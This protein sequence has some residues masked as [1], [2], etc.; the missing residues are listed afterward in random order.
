MTSV[1]KIVWFIS[2]CALSALLFPLH[3]QAGNEGPPELRVRRFANADG[4]YLRGAFS[5]LQDKRGF[6]LLGTERGLYRYDGYRCKAMFNDHRAEFN[7]EGD[8]I[9]ILALETEPAPGGSTR[10]WLGTKHHG[11]LRYDPLR[12]TLTH[13]PFGN[14]LTGK[15]GYPRITGIRFGGAGVV[16]VGTEGMGL[17][18]FTP[19]KATANLPE[20]GNGAARG[21]GTPR[22]PDT[23]YTIRQ[24]TEKDGLCHAAVF[25]LLLSPENTL[26]IATVKGLNRLFPDTGKIERFNHIV[27]NSNTICH[28]FT[29]VLC[30]DKSN[31]LWVGT[32][33][34][35]TRI[36]AGHVPDGRPERDISHFVHSPG[37]ES[38]LSENIINALIVDSCDNLWVGT[39]LQGVNRLDMKTGK[40][41]RF[42]HSATDLNTIDHNQILSLFEDRRGII[43]VGTHEGGLNKLVPQ[44]KFKTYKSPYDECIF[45]IYEDR[46]GNL[47]FSGNRYG[48]YRFDRSLPAG[49]GIQLFLEDPPAAGA[50]PRSRV[51]TIMEDRDGELWFGTLRAGLLRLKPGMR[52]KERFERV[53]S[54]AS[55]TVSVLMEDRDGSIWCG[56]EVGISLLAVAEK[57]K[58]DFRAIPDTP[59]YATALLEDHEGKLWIGTPFQGLMRRDKQNG[60]VV[61]YR[62]NHRSTKGLSNDAITAL[63]EDEEGSLWIGT[64]GGGLNRMD[65]S[66]KTFTV[67]TVADGLPSNTI[68][69]ILEDKKGNLWLSTYMGITRFTPTT[70]K[71]IIYD[72]HDGLQDYEFNTGASYKSKRTGEMFFGGLKGFNAFYPAEIVANPYVPPI[73]IT[74][75]RIFSKTVSLKERSSEG[76]RLELSYLDAMFSFEF[77]ALDYTEPSKNRYAYKMEGLSDKWI[78]SGADNRRAVF[79]RLPPGDYTLRIKGT[80][81]DGL[82]N[83][84]GIALD[85][86]IAPPFWRTWW[87]NGLVILLV[88]LTAYRFYKSRIKRLSQQLE[89]E[90]K[91]DAF[92]EK[93]NISVREKEVIRHL[94]RGRTRSQIEEALYI[95]PHTVKNHTYRIYKK[96]GIKNKTELMALFKQSKL[97]LP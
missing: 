77:S 12:E 38:S 23:N 13:I 17:Y 66:R 4:T 15:I 26:W 37:D 84:T 34:G 43:W 67:F 81:S 72:I 78:Y 24:Y 87:F 95:S 88:L 28:D 3:A 11:L 54:I 19:T 97:L 89:N 91:L 59:K 93:Y 30:L 22:T 50:F 10:I 8:T 53:P 41:T 1:L 39:F 5:I 52:G 74:D 64:L 68:G 90:K 76:S 6:L 63:H 94:V 86:Y 14:S 7:L 44:K 45:P 32:L 92:L 69:G 60:A 83:E 96:L 40:F 62:Q 65:P 48:V 27:G 20:T 75:F 55:R 36:A 85:I 73:Q 18:K 58:G 56:D 79:T 80:N 46:D 33:N 31:A 51:S 42:Q 2:V 49:R 47:W 35:L 21:T 82:W 25:S 57:E 9:S 29:R 61:R 70:G 16:W 71:C